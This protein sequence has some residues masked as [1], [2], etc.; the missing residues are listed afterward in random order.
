MLII[1]SEEGLMKQ[2]KSSSSSDRTPGKAPPEA[3]AGPPTDER[4]NWIPPEQRGTAIQTTPEL[5]VP[6]LFTVTWISI[7]TLTIASIT[8]SCSGRSKFNIG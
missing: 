8:N 6:K 4:G 2:A 5:E 7:G 3:K 1:M